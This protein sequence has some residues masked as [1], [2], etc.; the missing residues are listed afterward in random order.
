MSDTQW[1]RYMVFHQDE[2]GAAHQHFGT[3]HGADAEIALQNARDVFVRRPYCNNIWVVP[4]DKILMKTAQQLLTESEVFKNTI[5]DKEKPTQTYHLFQKL[6]QAGMVQ[7]IGEVQAT[8][9]KSAMGKALKEFANDKALWW[10]IL[11]ESTIYSSERKDLLSMFEPAWDKTSFRDQ[12]K[13]LTVAELRK[14]RAQNRK[15]DDDKS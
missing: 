5:D 11:P 12:G 13:F 7:W 2:E 9:S 6:S 1:E 14:I 15:K 4:V 10:W 8:S 3:V